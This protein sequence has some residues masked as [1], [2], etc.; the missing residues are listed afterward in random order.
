MTSSVARASSGADEETKIAAQASEA[1]A[2]L[3]RKACR[4]ML[5]P[6]LTNGMNCR[7][8]RA[9]AARP[10][11]DSFRSGVSSQELLEQLVGRGARVLRR[12]D[13]HV[14]GIGL[15]LDLESQEGATVLLTGDHRAH[16]LDGLRSVTE[17]EHQPVSGV[18]HQRFSRQ[19]SD[20]SQPFLKVARRQRAGNRQRF[21]VRLHE[22]IVFQSTQREDQHAM[23]HAANWPS[24]ANPSG[25]MKL[26]RQLRWIELEYVERD[27]VIPRALD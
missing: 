1:K 2:A 14:H 10:Q 11:S 23:R 16:A 25:P 19:L 9:I 4:N 27:L 15:L 21:H 17:R 13:R 12:G 24:Q 6:P 20:Q 26:A 3:R 5:S 18:A 8:V 7:G 22:S